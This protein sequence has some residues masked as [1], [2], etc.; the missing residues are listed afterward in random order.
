MRRATIE[1]KAQYDKDG[2]TVVPSLFSL[3]E[4]KSYLEHFM[5]LHADGFLQTGQCESYI[6]EHDPLRE[7]PRMMMPHR[8]DERSREWLLD[9]RIADVLRDLLEDE[10]IAAQTMFYFKPPG[11]RGQALH[12]DQFYLR[13]APGTCAA[14]WIALDRADEE[15]GC[16]MV[17]PRSGGL[18]RLCTIP[19]DLSISISD[20]TVELPEGVKPEF[21]VMEPGDALFF[22][23]SAIHGSLPNTSKSRF[24]RSMISHYIT[25]SASQVSSFYMPLIRMNGEEYS[26]ESSQWGGPCGV[27]KES[28]GF[29]EMREPELVGTPVTE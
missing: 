6:M 27:W 24:R 23:G 20:I 19:A 8:A 15:N 7:Y 29:V 10:P 9:S 4:I 13:A 3:E 16:M 25:G 5:R 2:Y 26:I 22:N 12:Q 1:Q 14:C 21:M 17:V 18:P 28:D 11:A